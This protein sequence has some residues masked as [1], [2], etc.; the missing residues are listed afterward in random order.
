METEQ[1]TSEIGALLRGLR[2][3]DTQATAVAWMARAY[4]A[5]EEC[6]PYLAAPQRGLVFLPAT[7]KFEIVQALPR[8][9]VV[10]VRRSR[11]P[12]SE[13]VVYP[14][15]FLHPGLKPLPKAWSREDTL[16]LVRAAKLNPV[17]IQKRG[18]R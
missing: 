18:G 16:C 6:I 13:T 11:I 17:I 1:L 4:K 7:P 8:E 9:P 12:P 5:M 15:M 2:S 14:A 3:C 10:H